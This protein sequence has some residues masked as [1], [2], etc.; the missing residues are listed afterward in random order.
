MSNLPTSPSTD[1]PD[2]I[3]RA[4]QALA[5]SEILSTDFSISDNIGMTDATKADIRKLWAL[6]ADI[7]L[8][9]VVLHLES[10]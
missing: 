10:K 3:R 4:A 7:E 1:L 8:G 9:R 2:V 5:V 6:A